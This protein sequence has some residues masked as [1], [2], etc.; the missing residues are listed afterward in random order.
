[1]IQSHMEKGDSFI[2]ILGV[3]EF[4]ISVVEDDQLRTKK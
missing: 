2:V 1:M 4:S 3:S